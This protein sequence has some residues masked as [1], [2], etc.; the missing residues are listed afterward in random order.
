MELVQGM[1]LPVLI[2]DTIPFFRYRLVT[3]GG[4]ES[5]RK[6]ARKLLIVSRGAA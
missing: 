3:D 4:F 1:P 6:T 5:E 2:F